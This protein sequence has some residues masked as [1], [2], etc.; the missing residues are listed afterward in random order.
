[1]TVKVMK[2]RGATPLYYTKTVYFDGFGR[3]ISSRS[4]GPAG[5]PIAVDTT[6]DAS[7]RVSEK[8]LPHFVGG[9]TENV[10]YAYDCLGRVTRIQTHGTYA[11]TSYL[12]DMITTTDPMGNQKKVQKDAY[13]RV[14]KVTELVS[15]AQVT[16]YQ[17]DTLGNLVQVSD[18]KGN[19]TTITYDSLSRK[20]AMSDPDMGKWSYLYDKNGNLTGQTDAKNQTIA[21]QYDELSRPQKRTTWMARTLKEFRKVYLRRSRVHQ[22]CGKTYVG[23]GPVGDLAL[24]LRRRGS[25][26]HGAK[27]DRAD[28]V[29]DADRLRPA[30]PR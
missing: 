22:R 28:H 8:S 2:V 7:G 16:L 11:T 14:V 30:R 26:D 18:A 23:F 4:D 20:I 3:D 1:M 5:T 17:Y 19:Q 21:Y 13:G 6:Y 9:A 10:S 24:L 15:P 29:H 25:N 12:Q 27:N